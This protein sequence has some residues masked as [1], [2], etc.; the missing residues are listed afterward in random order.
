LARFLLTYSWAFLLGLDRT[1]KSSFEFNTV[2]RKRLLSADESE[3]SLANMDQTGND[4]VAQI[5]ALE[6]K[7]LVLSRVCDKQKRVI[8]NLENIIETAP[9]VAFQHIDRDGRLRW[10]A[11]VCQPVFSDDNRFLGRR[12]S[13]MDITEQRWAEAELKATRDELEL[14]VEKRTI[15]LKNTA[16][17][18]E[19]KQADLL[20]SQADLKKLNQELLETSKAVS[21]LAKT[22]DEK[23]VETEKKIAFTISSKIIP[24]V[25]RLREDMQ[26]S[27]SRSE[28]DVIAAYLHELTSHLDGSGQVISALS[29]AEARVA[30]LIKSGLSTHEPA[31][32]LNISLLTAKAHRRNILKKLS[33][34]H[35]KENL[36]L[37]L[38]SRIGN[39]SAVAVSTPAGPVVNPAPP[40]AAQR[41]FRSQSTAPVV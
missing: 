9:E 13:N 18:F 36:A 23:K 16:E 25:N 33:L 32:R 7:N 37:Y 10:I 34:H 14:R 6:K 19:K 22:L 24:L 20:G 1:D 41:P 26:S 21:V 31:A 29:A 39:A 17:A 28:L 35:S 27:P 12:A 15:E 8:E 5:E 4:I 3:E 11:H 2:K 38:N 40:P 30:M